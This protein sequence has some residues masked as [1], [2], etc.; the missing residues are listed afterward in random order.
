MTTYFGI[1][2]AKWQGTI[3]WRKVKQEGVKFAILKV[4]Q[5]NNAVE[6]AFERNYSGT[7]ATGVPV[8]ITPDGEPPVDPVDPDE[9]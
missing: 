8:T 3:D 2:V 7:V 9:L 6:G 5:K 1:D 4:T